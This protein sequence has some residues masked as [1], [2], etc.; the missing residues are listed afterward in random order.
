M[1]SV[2]ERIEELHEMIEELDVAWQREDSVVSDRIDE[3]DEEIRR[4]E[5]KI[6]SLHDTI[7][8]L[9]RQLAE[10]E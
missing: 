1:K 8:S 10:K 3:K 6:E 5:A 4:L 2:Y 7:Y 9:E